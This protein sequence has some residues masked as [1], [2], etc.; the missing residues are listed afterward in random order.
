[1]QSQF[2]FEQLSGGGAAPAHRWRA[3]GLDCA[4]STGAVSAKIVVGDRIKAQ[5]IDER[6]LSIT[7]VERLLQ[8]RTPHSAPIVLHIGQGIDYARLQRLYACA[9]RGDK[10]ISLLP[11]QLPPRASNQSTHK[12]VPTN[13]AI[14]EPIARGDGGYEASLLLDERSADVSDHLT[15]HHIPGMLVAE[16]ARQ[17]MIAVAER[18]YLP[19]QRRAP[20]RFITHEM[21]LEYHDF[22]VPLPVQ[23]LFIP[24]KLRRVGDSNLKL[25]CEIRFTQRKRIGA[26]ARF[27]VS[28]IDRRYLESREIALFGAALDEVSAS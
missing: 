17:M 9:E 4:E 21:S 15:G 3:S 6:L 28:V 16:A 7:E 23:L 14:S 5:C 25:S 18:F 24:V 22:M 13:I 20:V 8:T 11:R 12:H 10:A 26:I 27:E 1:M 2:G 19:P